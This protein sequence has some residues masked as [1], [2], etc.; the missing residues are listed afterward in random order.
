[1]NVLHVCADP[2]PTEESVTKQMA[3]KFFSKMIDLNPSMEMENVDLYEEKP[4]FYTYALY[5]RMWKPIFEEDYKPSKEEDA[6]IH[7]AK[8]ET[9]RFNSADVLVLTAPMWNSGIPAIL[10]AWID[11]VIAPNLTFQVTGEAPKPLHR[12][13]TVVLLTS[14]G[15]TYDEN[16]ERDAVTPAIRTPF[17]SIGV[18]EIQIAWADGQDVLKNSDSE[19]RRT[20]AMEFVEEIAEDVSGV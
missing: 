14:S 19:L 11:Q 4:P 20:L 12:I 9:E 1:M 13:K 18:D 10:K 15:E 3:T 2:K 7:Y 16:D 5:Q 17:Q 6:A 8:R